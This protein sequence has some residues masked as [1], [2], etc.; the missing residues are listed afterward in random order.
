VYQAPRPPVD[1]RKRGRDDGVIRRAE[2]D[3]LRKRET[4]DHARL[5]VV[6]QALTR[7]AVDQRV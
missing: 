1:E 6:G 7:R 5:R 4:E 2:A 3:F